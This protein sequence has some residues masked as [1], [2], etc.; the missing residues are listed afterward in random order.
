MVEPMG[1]YQDNYMA[2][3]I[4]AVVINV[5]QSI[6]HDKK[7]SKPKT[8][9][10]ADFMPEWGLAEDSG[11]PAKPAKAQTIDEMKAVFQ[12]LAGKSPRRGKKITRGRKPPSG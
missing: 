6:F 9:T 2:S 7:S 12:Q 3:M 11:K 10:P 8:F 1:H 4:C 5:V